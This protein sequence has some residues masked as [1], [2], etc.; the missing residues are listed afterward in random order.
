MTTAPD[1]SHEK[2]AFSKQG[3]LAGR[4]LDPLIDPIHGAPSHLGF[5]R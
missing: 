1:H 5:D 3:P 4:Y 2:M